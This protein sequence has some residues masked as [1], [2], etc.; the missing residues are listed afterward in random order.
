MSHSL[1]IVKIIIFT[2]L[3]SSCSTLY[4]RD[5]VFILAGQSNMQGFGATYELRNNYRRTPHNVSFYYQGYRRPVPLVRGARFG[6]EVGFAHRLSRAFPRDRIVLIKVAAGG[7]AITEWMPGT[8]YYRSLLKQARFAM[9]QSNT[10]E[11]DAILWMQGE[12]DAYIHPRAHRYAAHL[13]RLITY[14][15][16]DLKSPQS[17]FL[18]GQINPLAERFP[19]VD[20][21]RTKQMLVNRRIYGTLLVPTRGLEKLPDQ[22]HYNTQGQLKLGERFAAAYLRSG[23]HRRNPQHYASLRH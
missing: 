2:L 10:R 20:I 22:L 11:V 19:L 18:I 5:R 16:R 4:A 7:S 23:H 17:L 1:F 21:V 3:L 12:S 6:P 8:H 14:L 15:R 13:Q 9:Q